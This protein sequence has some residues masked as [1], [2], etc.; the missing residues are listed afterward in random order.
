MYVM[1]LKI[2]RSLNY[3]WC[4]SHTF[5]LLGSAYFL[6]ASSKMLVELYEHEVTTLVEINDSFVRGDAVTRRNWRDFLAQ[7]RYDSNSRYSVITGPFTEDKRLYSY[8]VAYVD[9]F[10]EEIARL[11]G[12]WKQVVKTYL[13][14]G[15]QP[16]ING[17]AGGR[18][19]NTICS[20]NLITDT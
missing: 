4:Y 20:H 12:D 14:T 7:K 2:Q 11:N 17:Y 16:L 13:F 15:P 8:T 9:F 3:G 18:K 10:D 5:K 1:E 6:G 19:S